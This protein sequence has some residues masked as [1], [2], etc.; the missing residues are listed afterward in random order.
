MLL[1]YI[2]PQICKI[3]EPIVHLSPKQVIIIKQKPSLLPLTIFYYQLLLLHFMQSRFIHIDSS[4]RSLIM[5]LLQ[6]LTIVRQTSSK[7]WTIVELNFLVT[8][9]SH[10]YIHLTAKCFFPLFR[11]VY[12]KYYR[13]NKIMLT[14]TTF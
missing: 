7:R 12:E 9:L 13:A 3:S 10:T 14:L 2:L 11:L 4:H 5:P 1:Q 6:T 8:A